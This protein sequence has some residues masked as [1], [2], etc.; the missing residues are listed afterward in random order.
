MVKF[1]FILPDATGVFLERPNRFLARVKIRG[2]K[3]KGPVEV[4]VHDP[5]RLPDLLIPERE[6][7]LRRARNPRLRKTAWDLIAVRKNDHWVL[8]HSGLHRRIAEMLLA[9]SLTNPFGPAE[10]LAEPRRGRHRLDFLLTA[11]TGSRIWLEVKGCTLARGDLALFPDA[12][13]ARGAGHLRELISLKEEGEG[14]AVFFLVFRPEAR[15]FAP[16]REV[17]PHFADLLKEA[18]SCGVGVYPF[19]LEYQPHEGILLYRGL[20][21]LVLC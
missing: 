20:L 17:D 6:V 7:L 12:P 16:Y 1:P 2:G 14:A 11:E 5:G 4:H 9:H 15:R 13:T 10:R 21:P 8:V 3:E 18:V 19:L